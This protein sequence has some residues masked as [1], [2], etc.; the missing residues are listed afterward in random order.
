LNT[1]WFMRPD[2]VRWSQ[3]AAD[4]GAALRRAFTREN[5][6]ADM[7]TLLT[8]APL[9]ILVWIYAEQQQLVT[10]KDTLVVALQSADPVHRSVTLINPSDGTIQVTLQ[11]SE[12]GIDRVKAELRQTIMSKPLPVDVP[13]GLAPGRQQLVALDEIAGSN[14]F[15]SQGVTVT[16]CLPETLS[17]RVDELSERTAPVEVDS[18]VPGLLNAAFTPATVTVRGPSQ[19]LDDLAFRGELHAVANLTGQPILKQPG[20]HK[21]LTVSLIPQPNITLI[22]DTVT[23]DLSIGQP[24]ATVDVSPVP[25]KIEASKWLMDNY[26]FSYKEWITDAVTLMGPR[27]AIAQINPANARVTAVVDLDYTDA[28]F[29]GLK[30]VHFQDS[31]L[32]DGVTVKPEAKP[33]MIQIAVDPR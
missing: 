5:L 13:A 17:V 22:P 21:Q 31:G 15:S 6:I 20:E 28:D 32:P 29:H 30:T 14:L 2:K 25:V 23:A 8:V 19:L 10:D 24:D 16:A 7:K 18:D 11:G 12:I 4:A 9:T 26:K 3:R 33:R 27:Q 1:P